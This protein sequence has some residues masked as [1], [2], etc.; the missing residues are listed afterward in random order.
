MGGVAL[1]FH[2]VYLSSFF[3]QGLALP[4]Y[5][6]DLFASSPEDFLYLVGC[7]IL[8][9]PQLIYFTLINCCAMG[10][11][12]IITFYI[13]KPCQVVL[14]VEILLADYCLFFTLKMG[15]YII[16]LDDVVHL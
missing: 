13:G 6:R 11:I 15:R 10:G 9:S 5:T 16:S 14:F 12:V 7:P 4:L 2:I 8:I 3:T 1:T